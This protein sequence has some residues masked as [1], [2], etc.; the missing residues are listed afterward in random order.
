MSRVWDL[1]LR[2]V[3]FLLRNVDAAT[4]SPR[5]LVDA[6]ADWGANAILLNGG[7]F[8]A[9]Y[10]TRLDY[11]PPNAHMQGDFLGEAVERAQERG[12]LVLARMDISKTQPAVA[13]VHPEWLRR[14]LDGSIAT[15]W[16]MPETCFTGEYWRR[17]NFEIVDELLTRYPIDGLFYNM[18][19][20]AHCHCER[21]QTT[22]RGE[23]LAGV[24]PNADAADPHWR[25][26]ELWRRRSLAG[27]TGRL[28]D[29]VH[30]VRPGAALMVYH[31]QKEGWD[32]PAMAA[33]T[34]LVSVTAS[35]PLA[36][37]PLSP[38]PAWVGWP[39]YEAALARGLKPDRPGV[40]VTTTSA[41]FASRRAAQ[42]AERVR[43]GQLQVAFQRG[44]PCDAIPGGLTQ[45]DPRALP[46]VANTLTWL[47]RHADL[48]EHLESPARVAL[49]ASR[50]T[51]DLCPLP[52]EGDLSRR[53]EWGA[54]LALSRARQPFD[55][56]PLDHAGADLAQYRVAVLPD[57][58]CMADADAAAIDR[59]V[60][61]GG[62][63]I[64]TYLAGAF[65]ERG[66][67]RPHSPLR[68]LGEP[69]VVSG[70]HCAGGY[71]ALTDPE[72]QQIFGGARVLGLDRELLH[73]EWMQPPTHS[74]LH[75][76]G[77][78]RNN[79]PEFADIP[80]D[81]RGPAGLVGRR[82]GSGWAWHLPWRPGT[83]ISMNGL[84]DPAALLSELVRRSVGPAPVVIEPDSAAIEAR[85]WL[86][87]GRNRVVLLLLNAT[88][89]QLSPMVEVSRL[90]ELEV[91]TALN[92]RRVWSASHEQA[93][94]CTRTSNGVSVHLP[95][96]DYAD[97]L[98]FEEIEEV[99]VAT[100][101][102]SE[103]SSTWT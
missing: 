51:L 53:E 32:V 96:L 1:P 7:G 61:A 73:L 27:Y 94:P 18:Y 46:G 71:L 55:V 25:A 26:Y 19:R 33:A 99:L 62:T 36:V 17:C 78:V 24:P 64:A 57:V 2:V 88:A 87:P 10:P 102:R 45:D 4:E 48:F 65:D 44:A 14:G 77:P 56:V 82:Y 68:C 16:E 58:A 76:L 12:L 100:T 95:W 74:D 31:H 75:L 23:G 81:Q 60:D 63:L 49:L 5:A 72:L 92:P 54:Y 83:L 20:I 101:S 29:A 50:D 67:E 22:V 103:R 66:Q 38:Q 59:W 93:L 30:C 70:Q 79:T 3:Q 8:S 34:D 37:N 11:Q 69:R 47:A 84:V 6:A 89:L 52:G 40:V 15:E 13:A 98:V 43:L 41:F 86:Q 90:A 9:W 21:C 42:S 35:V 80:F 91:R 39:G 85:F 28:R 97:A